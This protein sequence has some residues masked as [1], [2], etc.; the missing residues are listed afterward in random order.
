MATI[1]NRMPALLLSD[2]LTSWLDPDMQ[3]EQELRNLLR[4]Y[5][6]E[7]MVAR[8]VSRLVNDPR[9]DGVELIA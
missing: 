4:P 6:T 2:A 1:H 8:P 9:R 3:D 5:P 7:L